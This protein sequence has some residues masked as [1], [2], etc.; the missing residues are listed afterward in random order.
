[1]KKYIEYYNEDF[2]K[3]FGPLVEKPRNV[4]CNASI[5]LQKTLDIA[6]ILELKQKASLT[7]ELLDE[8]K[9]FMEVNTIISDIRYLAKYPC[10]LTNPASGNAKMCFVFDAE[11][12]RDIG[13]DGISMPFSHDYRAYRGLLSDNDSMIFPL[14]IEERL[15]TTYAYNLFITCISRQRWPEART[16]FV[17]SVEE[18]RKNMGCQTKTYK[19]FR[20]FRSRLLDPIID[21]INNSGIY[22]VKPHT[23]KVACFL[24]PPLRA[25]AL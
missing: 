12:C 16:E 6:S 3:M 20:F 2:R 1:M 9:R 14:S 13:L 23:T 18:L 10:V 8:V 4:F 19:Q 22:K 21:E 25:V 15:T 11:C 7:T 5:D 17:L 24:L